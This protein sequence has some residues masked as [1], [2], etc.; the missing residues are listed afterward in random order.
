MADS[1]EVKFFGKKTTKGELKKITQ[2]E[3]VIA[4]EK[5]VKYTMTFVIWFLFYKSLT[6]YWFEK[7]LLLAMLYSMMSILITMSNKIYSIEKKLKSRGV[8]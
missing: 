1:D 5:A 2:E 3:L 6:A 4:S 7:D 8:K